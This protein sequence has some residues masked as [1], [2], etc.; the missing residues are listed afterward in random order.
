MEVGSLFI[1]GMLTP[2]ASAR[3]AGRPTNVAVRVEPPAARIVPTNYQRC[4]KSTR[5]LIMKMNL[6][7]IRNKGVVML[8]FKFSMENGNFHK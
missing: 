4:E 2:G 1:W 6:A 7:E 8:L 5:S 3:N